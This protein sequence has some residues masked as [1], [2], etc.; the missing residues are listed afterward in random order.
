M[1]LQAICALLPLFLDSLSQKS[2]TRHLVVDTVPVHHVEYNDNVD[3]EG[4]SLS[5]LKTEAG[6]LHLEWWWY[7]SGECAQLPQAHVSASFQD[8]HLD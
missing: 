7:Q 2:Y 5:D 4:C 6:M 1:K 3:D 8:I